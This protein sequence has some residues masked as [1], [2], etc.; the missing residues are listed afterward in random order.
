[1]SENT[2]DSCD[3]VEFVPELAEFTQ[4]AYDGACF[5]EHTLECNVFTTDGKPDRSRSY[6]GWN[7]YHTCFQLCELV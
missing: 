6:P 3:S 2:S 4:L 5:V 1:M 7:T